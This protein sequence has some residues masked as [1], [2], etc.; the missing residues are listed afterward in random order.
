MIIFFPHWWLSYNKLFYLSPVFL[1]ISLALS[2]FHQFKLKD[3]QQRRAF[4]MIHL[5]TFP[6]RS[7]SGPIETTGY[8]FWIGLSSRFLFNDWIDNLCTLPTCGRPPLQDINNI[9]QCVRL[10]RR[11]GIKTK[12]KKSPKRKENARSSSY[13]PCHKSIT[14]GSGRVI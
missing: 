5:Q 10:G 3:R 9:L 6:R 8:S 2:L 11:S 12:Y 7:K 4:S 1:S 13:F 14:S